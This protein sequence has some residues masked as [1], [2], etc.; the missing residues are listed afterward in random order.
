MANEGWVKLYRKLME[1]PI[2]T[3]DADHLAIW[4]YLLL[5][6]THDTYP[7]LFKGK[8]IML[9]PGQLLTGR[10]EISKRLCVTESKVQRVLNAFKNEHQIEQ[11]T[12]NKNRLIS[13]INWDFYQGSEQQN[14]L[15]MNNKR[16]TS[17]QQVN[18][19][20]NV[21][22][23]KNVNKKKKEDTNVSKKKEVEVYYPN[24]EKLNQAFC[25][26]AEMR[27]QIKKPM[28]E[29]AVSL[30]MKKLKE[31]SA[32]PFSDEMDNDLAI[33]ILEQSTM[34]SWLGLFAIKDNGSKVERG[35]R[36]LLQELMDA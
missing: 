26:Y 28:T 10:K 9:E 11:Q 12:S 31:L 2:V 30:A 29:R 14:E 23:I 24:D 15:Q 33:K 27:R 22:N 34:N 4:I 8:K 19:N 3:K 17:E 13:I 18:T 1:N 36:D 7:S 35:K 5:N 16:T 32:V 25:D 6:A 21:N 20:K